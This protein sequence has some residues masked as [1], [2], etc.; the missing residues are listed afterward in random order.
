MSSRPS[1]RPETRLAMPVMRAARVRS[2][3]SSPAGDRACGAVLAR[4]F[5]NCH[6]L[7]TERLVIDT[8]TGLSRGRTAEHGITFSAVCS[9]AIAE[10]LVNFYQS[11]TAKVLLKRQK[12]R[13]LGVGPGSASY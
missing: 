6:C 13:R 5:T 2:A 10:K 7:I 4:G 12:G 11:L 8:V 3:C 9:Y 1:A